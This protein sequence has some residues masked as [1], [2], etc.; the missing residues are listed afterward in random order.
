MDSA[1]QEHKCIVVATGSECYLCPY[2]LSVHSRFL[3]MVHSL[4]FLQWMTPD[5]GK[6]SCLGDTTLFTKGC[7]VSDNWLTQELKSPDPFLWG[8]IIHWCL[9]YEISPGDY[10]EVRFQINYLG[11]ALSPATLPFPKSLPNLSL[12]PWITYKITSPGLPFQGTPGIQEPSLRHS[13]RLE[14]SCGVCSW[15]RRWRWLWP[16][17]CF[18]ERAAFQPRFLLWTVVPSM[19]ELGRLFSESV[20]RTLVYSPCDHHLLVFIVVSDSGICHQQS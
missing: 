6:L 10:A 8:E 15:L 3:L 5:E 1:D 7:P 2:S 9:H 13:D 14:A 19:K 11:L 20:F 17:I 12:P 18:P 4:T 16:I